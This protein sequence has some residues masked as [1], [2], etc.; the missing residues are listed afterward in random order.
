MVTEQLQHGELAPLRRGAS[1]RV[2]R[3]RPWVVD[4]LRAHRV[5]LVV[6]RLLAGQHW[7]EHGLV[8]PG[9]VGTPRSAG[10]MWLSWKQLL[11]RMGLPDYK[12]HELRHTAASLRSRRAR[13][14]STS[15][16]C[17]GTA[18]SPSPPTRMAIGPTTV[19]RTW[20]NGSKRH[21][22]DVWLSTWLSRAA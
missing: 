17:V 10:N 6:Q 21:F 22:L 20:R 7:Q 4:A 13:A 12:F 5:Q 16:E 3:L 9:R 2:L 1:R 15:R 19:A 14:S 18:R 8:F 11:K